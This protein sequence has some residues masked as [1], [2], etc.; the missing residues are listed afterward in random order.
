MGEGLQCCSG[1]PACLPARCRPC[2]RARP[3]S[4]QHA[5]TATRTRSPVRA[6]PQQLR[7]PQQ[8]HAGPEVRHHPGGW[9]ARANTNFRADSCGG[10]DGASGLPAPCAWAPA[11]CCFCWRLRTCMHACMHASPPPFSPLAAHERAERFERPAAC[12]ERASPPDPTACCTPWRLACTYWC[13]APHLTPA[14]AAAADCGRS[15]PSPT[16]RR[17]SCW[18]TWRMWKRCAPLCAVHYCYCLEPPPSIQAHAQSFAPYYTPP[19]HPT[20]PPP[21]RTVL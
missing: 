13:A 3:R 20:S 14:P 1:L 12:P 21:P 8:R 18:S 10:S 7:G 16:G 17:A 6:V 4:P 2:L 11:C 15:K 9:R 5:H 19:H